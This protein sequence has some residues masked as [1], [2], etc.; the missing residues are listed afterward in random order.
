MDCGAPML[1]N[2]EPDAGLDSFRL[3]RRAPPSHELKIH[4]TVEKHEGI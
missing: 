3:E 1:V 4:G 2:I